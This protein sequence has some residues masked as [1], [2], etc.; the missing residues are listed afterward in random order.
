MCRVSGLS[1]TVY[2]SGQEFLAALEKD[3]SGADCLILDTHMPEMSGIELLRH[4]VAAGRQIPTVIFTADEA[5]DV[6]APYVEAKVVAYLRKPASA[7]SLLNAISLALTALGV[8]P[9]VQRTA[10]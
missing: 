7:D 5:S 3:P 10:F 4:L 9:P 1:P 8:Q 2:T 6:P